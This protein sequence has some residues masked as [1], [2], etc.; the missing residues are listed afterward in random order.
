MLAGEHRHRHLVQQRP[1]VAD[2]VHLVGVEDDIG[3]GGSE[4]HAYLLGQA[5]TGSDGEPARTAGCGGRR[6]K[7][8]GC[9]DR[10][11]RTGKRIIKVPDGAACPP[12]RAPLVA[13]TARTD[14][15]GRGRIL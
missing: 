10:R 9:R 4:W 15:H 14:E 8:R 11:K 2:H 7:G 1:A 12:A 13:V 5:R 6:R 3:A